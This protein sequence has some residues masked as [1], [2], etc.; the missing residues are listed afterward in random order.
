M[1]T[2]DISSKSALITDIQRF[3]MHDGPG[4]RT[5]VF[6]KGCPLRCEWC[7]NPETQSSRPVV[8]FSQSQCLLCGACVQVCDQNAQSITQTRIFDRS[9]CI[10]CGKC[11][12]V[13]P[14]HAL[15]L[16][17]KRM[18][19]DEILREV[20]KDR[21][22]YG[23]SGGMTVSGGEPTMQSDALF[24]LLG[25][26]K[27]AG[28]Q[29]A[30]ETCGVFAQS[31]V[32]RLCS[33]CDL[34]LFDIKD[35]NAERLHKNTGADLDI[36]LSNLHAIDAAGSAS[37]LRC[38]MIPNVN[39]DNEHCQGIEEIFKRLN[40]CRCVELL[41]YHPFGT[42]KAE[43]LGRTETAVFRKPEKEEIAS[44]ADSLRAKGVLVKTFGSE[45]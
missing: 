10:S 25:A 5:T 18:T 27:N 41:P 13:C 15:T 3:C 42:S 21:V 12:D 28:I 26:S 34:F 19:V 31:M 39:M 38:I 44:F 4:V 35:T 16:S 7:H 9:L 6:F 43:Q 40:C 23:E 2:N 36:V 11:A 37:V 30:L 24:A 1:K 8:L 32:K 14:S 45:K 17:G 22:F 33:L 29:T 20:E